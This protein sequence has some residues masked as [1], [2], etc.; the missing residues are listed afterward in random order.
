MT[1]ATF[2]RPGTTR[3]SPANCTSAVRRSAADL[4][5]RARRSAPAGRPGLPVR[6]AVD[7][8]IIPDHYIFRML[9]SQGIALEALGIP[10]RDGGAVESDHRKIWQ[11]VCDHW[12][13]FRG[14]P[15]GVWLRDELRD[16]FGIEPKINSAE[17]A[18]DLRRDC[19]QAG[20][21]GISPAR[22]CSSASTSR[23]WRP[24]TPPPTRWNIIRRSATSGWSGRVIPTFRPD[25]VVNLDT[26]GLARQHRH[27]ERGVRHRRERLCRVTSRRWSSGAPSS[28]RWAR[29]RPITPR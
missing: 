26:R 23:C 9:Y 25:A 3:R 28:S 7:L 4:P 2:R 22:A 12:Y 1:T 19:R 21:A 18:G 13:L 8:L 24:P 16:V 10:R 17:R 5:A 20:A 29:R 14:T 11:T 27:A 6:H 15:T